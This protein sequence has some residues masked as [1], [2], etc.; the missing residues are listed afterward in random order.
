MRDTM[1]KETKMFSLKRQIIGAV[2]FFIIIVA[3]L[4]ITFLASTISSYKKR[5]DEKRTKDMVSYA[6]TLD[7]NLAELRNVAGGIYSANNDFN[8]INLYPT[9][10]RKWN[11]VYNLLK[12]L[13]IQVKSNKGIA[14]MFLY[15]DSFDW[16]QYAVDDK[17]S[18]LAK[19]EIKKT[20][21]VE[22]KN[23]NKVYV[24]F[25][26]SVEADVWYNIYMKKASAAIGG[27]IRLSQG[28][29]DERDEEGIYGVIFEE[30]FHTVWAANGTDGEA[31]E[32]K[33]EQRCYSH[34]FSRRKSCEWKSRLSSSIKF[35]RH[36]SGGDP[37]GKYLAV[38]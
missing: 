9:P 16:V 23:S 24:S 30:K 5:A 29:P 19:E 10:A 38:Y 35:R 15:Y 1:K 2:W 4:L 37:A 21:K 27:C 36:V 14:G 32:K 17:V 25:I 34:A 22:L 33:T 8:E 7:G 13:R 28:L 26:Q 11:H 3:L 12:V 20:G 6:E 18:F 31:S